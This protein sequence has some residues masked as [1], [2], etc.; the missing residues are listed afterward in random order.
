M[1]PEITTHYGVET[2]FQSED[3]RR[4]RFHFVWNPQ[5]DLEKVVSDLN[6]FEHL[7]VTL[8]DNQLIVE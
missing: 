2:V 8:K 7:H 4:L 1:L 3:A 6:H 5:A